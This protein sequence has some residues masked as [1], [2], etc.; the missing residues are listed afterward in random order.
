MDERINHFVETVRARN[1]RESVA[2]G[3]VIAFLGYRLIA[4]P[5]GLNATGAWIVIVA[6]LGVIAFSLGALNIPA[7]EPTTHPLAQHP[8]HWRRRMTVQAKALRFAWLWY[9]LPLLG[10]VAVIVLGRGGEFTTGTMISLAILVGL[11]A[12]LSYAN[13][14]AASRMERDRDALLG[15]VA[16]T[17]PSA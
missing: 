12:L 17:P 16:T 8:E 3:V 10:G 4:E 2:A 13:I 1:V 5:E 9:V 6:C 11:G 15:D 14:S 7:S